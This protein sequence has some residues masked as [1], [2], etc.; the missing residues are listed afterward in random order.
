[1][2]YQHSAMIVS[3]VPSKLHTQSIIIWYR[4][5]GRILY[6]D[7]NLSRIVDF[8]KNIQFSTQCSR[9]SNSY[10]CSDDGPP[11]EWGWRL[12]ENI[13]GVVSLIIWTLKYGMVLVRFQVILYHITSI[14]WTD[15]NHTMECYY[16]RFKYG[17]SGIQRRKS[18]DLWISFRLLT[19]V[20]SIQVTANNYS[21]GCWNEI[22]EVFIMRNFAATF[23]IL[24]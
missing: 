10:C 18:G 6:W 23:N 24:M 13:M 12:Y 14:F 16:W 20:I 21:L 4:L 3:L 8:K 7:S 22:Y 17:N 5:A 19:L 1:M 9:C 11:A 2:I 15:R